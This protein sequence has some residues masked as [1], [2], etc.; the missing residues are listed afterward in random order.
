MGDEGRFASRE[1]VRA[2]QERI[3]SNIAELRELQAKRRAI[4]EQRE[5]EGRLWPPTRRRWLF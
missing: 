1:E 3:R 2:R 4:F 5:I